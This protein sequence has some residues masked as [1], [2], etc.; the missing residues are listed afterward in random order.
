MNT[1]DT[2]ING[3]GPEG[4]MAAISSRFYGKKTLIL[5]KNKRMGKKLTGTGGGRCKVTNNGTQ[6]DLL[7]G[8]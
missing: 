5:E 3:A 4:M 6:D 8:I 1:V 2:S 7:A